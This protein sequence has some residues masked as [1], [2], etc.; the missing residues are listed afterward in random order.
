[1]E[2]SESNSNEVKLNIGKILP[3]SKVNGP[4]NRCVVWLQGCGIRCPHCMNQEFLP[5]EPRKEITVSELYETIA[6]MP[7]IE[8]VTYSGGEPFEQA[9]GLY[10]L[11]R[12]LKEKGLTIMSYS[13]NTY[14][15]LASRNDRYISS[16][17]SILDVLVDGGFDADKA[18]SLPWR[19]S[20]NQKVHFLTGKYKR[21]ERDIDREGVDME[22]SL[23]GSDVTVTGNFNGDLLQDIREKLKV[24]YGIIL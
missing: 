2:I 15:D 21:Y 13:G 22:F 19:G 24:D 8:G 9:K 1:M 7:E 17:L 12:K 14:S 6:S 11:S 23:M 16:L 20:R 3:Q 10:Y 5:R 18:A 4:G